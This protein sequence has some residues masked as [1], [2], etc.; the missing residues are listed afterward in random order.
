MDAFTTFTAVTSSAAPVHDG[1]N[2]HTTPALSCD[3]A[4]VVSEGA[5]VNE[6]VNRL[7]S[8]V[9]GCVIA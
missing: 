6:A 1:L 2:L 9:F 7:V 4:P 8:P 5:P 3:A